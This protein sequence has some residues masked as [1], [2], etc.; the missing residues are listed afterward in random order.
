MFIVFPPKSIHLTLQRE[1]YQQNSL[2]LY[3]HSP[4]SRIQDERLHKTVLGHVDK[5]WFRTGRKDDLFGLL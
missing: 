3:N 5:R 1:S 4:G 2:C